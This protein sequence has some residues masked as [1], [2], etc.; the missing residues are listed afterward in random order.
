LGDGSL[1]IDRSLLIFQ[2]PHPDN[3]T[4]LKFSPVGKNKTPLQSTQK[5]K[6]SLIKHPAA[7]SA[8]ALLGL[9]TVAQAA[10][11]IDN[12]TLNGSFEAP[13]VGGADAKQ[14]FDIVGRDIVSWANTTTTYSGG[15][16]ATYNDVG[17]DNN[18]GGAHSGNQFAFFHGG[19]GGAYNLTSY[20]IQSGDQFSL[21]WW[22]RADTIAVRLFSSTD[23]TYNTAATLFEVQQLQSGSYSQ[24]SL[25]YSA[26]AAD[27][28]KTL[29]VS[30]FNP[31]TGYANVDDIVLATVPEASTSLS[32]AFG[33]AA[34]AF[35]RSRKRLNFA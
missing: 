33:A 18:A 9:G 21:T 12:S 19:E 14:G 7:L 17:V 13:D 16:G 26:V 4:Q 6:N 22:G 32:L 8:I 15:L 28:G 23:G 29:G 1:L 3:G 35:S 27:V 34:L 11:L 24:Y 25:T 30:I 5:M 10:V 31:V 20:V 2:L